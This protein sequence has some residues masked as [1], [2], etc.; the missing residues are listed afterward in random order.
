V[1]NR[2]VK[3]EITGRIKTAGTFYQ[4]VSDTQEMKN[5]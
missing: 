1:K 3:R 5:A 4:L 2:N